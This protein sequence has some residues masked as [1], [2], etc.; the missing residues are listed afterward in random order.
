VPRDHWAAPWIERLAAEG[1]TGG[2][3]E[4]LYCP[5]RTTTR[6]ELA[7]FLARIFNL[8]LP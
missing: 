3:A 6:A 5:A 7:V 1:V 4:G 2:C 8:T